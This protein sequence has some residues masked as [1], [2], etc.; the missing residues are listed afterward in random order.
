MLIFLEIICLKCRKFKQKYKGGKNTKIGANP[1]SFLSSGQFTIA[2]WVSSNG[3][4]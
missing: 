3:I 2:K 1:R 4:Q